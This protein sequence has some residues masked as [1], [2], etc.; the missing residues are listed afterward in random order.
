[1]TERVLFTAEE[2][3]IPTPAN[4]SIATKV[5]NRILCDRRRGLA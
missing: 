5:K 1:M 3:E 2:F 4:T